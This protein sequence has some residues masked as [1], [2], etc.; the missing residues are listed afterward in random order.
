VTAFLAI[1]PGTYK[2]G[3][4]YFEDSRL[5]GHWLVTVDPKAEIEVRIPALIADV[6]TIVRAHSNVRAVACERITALEH[7][8][9][10]E[11]ATFVRRLRR[12]ATQKPHRFAW[13]D[14]HPSTVVASVRPR[15]TAG[16]G[17]KEVMKLG[18]KFLYGADFQGLWIDQNVIDAIAVG[19]CHISKTIEAERNDATVP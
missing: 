17:S 12:W 19:H 16:M 13:T 6:E 14:Y 11:L 3:V 15:G 8:P 1:D 4:A 9:A 7:R 2:T 10:P 18:V 5:L